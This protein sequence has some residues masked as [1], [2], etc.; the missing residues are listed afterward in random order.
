MI[1]KLCLEVEKTWHK[2]KGYRLIPLVLENQIFKD[3]EIA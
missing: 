1:Y 2:L 3:G